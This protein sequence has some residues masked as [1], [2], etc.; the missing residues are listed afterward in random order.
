MYVYFKGLV[1]ERKEKN[2]KNKRRIGTKILPLSAVAPLPIRSHIFVPTLF[3]KERNMELL[4]SNNFSYKKLHMFSRFASFFSDSVIIQL[5]PT[6]LN[7]C[8]IL[9]Q[10]QLKIT[11]MSH[12]N[13]SFYYIYFYVVAYG[14]MLTLARDHNNPTLISRI[15]S[16]S[17]SR[18]CD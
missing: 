10:L 15:N 8:T 17:G 14:Q 13:Q 12:S 2:K 11:H 3:E 7:I 6:H 4:F 9:Y 16:I 18:L 5:V 1:G